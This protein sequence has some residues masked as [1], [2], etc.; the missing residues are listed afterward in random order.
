MIDKRSIAYLVRIA[1]VT[2]LTAVSGIAAA[3]DV[4][5][6]LSGAEEV[7]AVTT[8]ATGGGTIK[9]GDDLSVSGSVKTE[10]ID[11]TAAHIHQAPVGQSGPPI[12]TLTKGDGGV[13]NVPAGSKLTPEQFEAFKA[14][15]L[16]VNVHSA[17]HKPGEIRGQLKH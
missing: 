1:A 17:A 7:P 8:S 14:G 15:N 12:I 9:I 4:K 6:K 3:H 11:G 2:G 5:V 13:W 10:G 16:Y